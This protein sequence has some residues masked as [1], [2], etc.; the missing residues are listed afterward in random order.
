MSATT[1]QFT[2]EQTDVL[3]STE[4]HITVPVPGVDK[5]FVI[6]SEDAYDILRRALKV[7][8]VDLPFFDCERVDTPDSL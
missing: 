3:L 1:F 7:D 6:I 4:D 2:P 8:H 5:R